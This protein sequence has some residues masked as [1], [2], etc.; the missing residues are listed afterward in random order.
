MVRLEWDLAALDGKTV[1]LERF[2]TAGEPVSILTT[3]SES[4]YI[5]TGLLP[6]TEYSWRLVILAPS[7]FSTAASTPLPIKTE[8]APTPANVRAIPAAADQI[9]RAHV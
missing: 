7:G 1:R 3:A 6:G 5:D 9:G 8:T 4:S 2:N